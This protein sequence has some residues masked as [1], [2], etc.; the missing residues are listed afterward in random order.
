MSPVNK[1]SD[2]AA[3]APARMGRSLSGNSMPANLSCVLASI[4]NASVAISTPS[5]RSRRRDCWSSWSR[6]LAASCA[7][8]TDVTSRTRCSFHRTARPACSRYA[9]ENRTFASR[10]TRQSCFGRGID[11]SWTP[12]PNLPWRERKFAHFF[13][14]LRIV[15]NI[16]SIIQ[17]EFRL[18]LVCISLHRHRYR[19]S[20]QNSAAL[21]LRDQQ[22]AFLQTKPLS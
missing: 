18:A 10:K 14:C 3:T 12:M 11:L 16:H 2:S 19:G 15:F 21:F 13:Y 4:P 7:A 20:Q 6:L 8:Y 5:S 1:K 17:Q 22:R 9:A